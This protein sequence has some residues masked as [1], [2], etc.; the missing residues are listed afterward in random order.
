MVPVA[1]GAPADA[2]LADVEMA[3]PAVLGPPDLWTLVPG[4]RDTLVYLKAA[5]PI[6]LYCMDETDGES[7]DACKM[8]TEGLYE[9]NYKGESLP[10]LATECVANA[11]ATVFT[12]TLREGVLFH[13][14]STFDANDVVRTWD[15]GFNAASEY[16]LGNTGAFEYPSY[17]FDALM[18]LPAE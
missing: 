6:S 1:H 11:D 12:C 7:L 8:T 2:A 5:E 13:D 15:A 18:N 16:H 4:D 17:L 3:L 14:G 9:Y 10:T